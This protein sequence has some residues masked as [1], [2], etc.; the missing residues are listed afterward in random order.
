MRDREGQRP[1]FQRIVPPG[2]NR[3][4][5]VCEACGWV[6][7]E[8]PKVVVG[9]VVTA[10]ERYLLCRRSI[11]PGA[12]RWTIPAGFLEQN[13]TT[14]DGARR[15]ALEEACARIEIDALLGIYEIPRLSQVQIVFRARLPREDASAGEETREVRFF[16]W[17]EIPWDELAFPS[18]RWFLER[19]R[20]VVDQDRFAPLFHRA[21]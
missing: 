16:R 14:H 5:L 20:T 2:D 9:S 8:N 7:Y 13:E 1:G 21:D 18:V 19:H 3:E 12:G 15:E 11:E 4:R 10:G 17:S 6:H